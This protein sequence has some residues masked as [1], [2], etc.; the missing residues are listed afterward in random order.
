MAIKSRLEE[1]TVGDRFVTTLTQRRGE[2]Q[3]KVVGDGVVVHFDNEVFDRTLH[4]DVV[5][6]L[7][8][9]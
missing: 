2:V 8:V 1:L 9:N 6:E 4:K 7:T 3:L 5:V